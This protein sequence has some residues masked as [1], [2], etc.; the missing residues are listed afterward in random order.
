MWEEQL[1]ARAKRKG[2]KD[3]AMGR[4]IV[5]GVTD[6]IPADKTNKAREARE[7]II[8]LNDQGYSNLITMIDT[9]KSGGKVAFSIIK[10]SKTREYPDGHIGVAMGGLKRKYAPKNCSILEQASQ[11]LLESQVEEEHQSRC[12]HHTPRRRL[13]LHEE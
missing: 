1:L 9:S 8:N 5:P 6:M 11:G 3:I 10:R 2:Y 12:L 13:R 4:V 7:K